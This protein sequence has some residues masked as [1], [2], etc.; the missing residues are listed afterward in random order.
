MAIRS[1]TVL[2]LELGIVAFLRSEWQVGWGR[3][4]GHAAL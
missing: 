2:L 4:A 3:D 1:L